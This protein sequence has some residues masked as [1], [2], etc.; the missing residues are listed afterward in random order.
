MSK[1]T[2]R[3]ITDQHSKPLCNQLILL[4]FSFLFFSHIAEPEALTTESDGLLFVLVL[5]VSLE[6][7]Y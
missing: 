7:Y 5:L 4:L 1:L 2:S 6:S 3:V